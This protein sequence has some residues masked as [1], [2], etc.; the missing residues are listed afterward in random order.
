MGVLLK[1]DNSWIDYTAYI[2]YDN[3]RFQT[4]DELTR[5]RI[6]DE[7]NRLA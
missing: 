4:E 6:V 2:Y 7:L 3:R 5:R 1:P